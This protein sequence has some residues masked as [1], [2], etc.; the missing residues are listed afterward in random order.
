MEFGIFNL[1]GARDPRTPITNSREEGLRFAENA[2][3][4]TRL[5][6]SLRNRQEVM[7]G[8]ALV[9][10]MAKGEESLETVHD[11]GQY[12]DDSE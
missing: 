2:R 1:M 10:V 12:D 4:Q 5:A 7:D 11:I 9:D 8:I 6:S 3:Y